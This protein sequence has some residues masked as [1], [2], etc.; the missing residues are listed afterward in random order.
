MIRDLPRRSVVVLLLSLPGISV[1][2][3]AQEP[4]PLKPGAV[5]VVAGK[6]ISEDELKRETSADL[7]KLEMQ[8][9][10]AEA[11]YE[12]GRYQVREN[13][14][15]KLIEDRLLDAEAA[16]L[17]I[18]RA[19]VVA[20]EID[21]KA[22]PP[23]D[24]EVD[25]FYETNK[26]RINRPKDQVGQQIRQYL[27]QQTRERARSA[28]MDRL[29]KEHQAVGS[30]EP[31][32]F[33]VEAAGH[34]ARG[35]SDAPLTIIEFSDFECGF[36]RNFAGVLDSVLKEFGPSVRFVYR[37]FP[38]VEIHPNAQKASEA[39][40]CAADQGKFWE[41]K[42]K[43][44]QDATHLTVPDLKAKAAALGLDTEAFNACL[45][46]GSQT[47]RVTRDLLDGSKVGVT[48]TPA[49]FINGRPFIGAQPAAELTK[50]I[51]EELKLRAAAQKP[52]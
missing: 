21:Q 48:G 14:L 43:L 9:L 28:L 8:K 3:S 27:A 19:E 49:L 15:N 24:A 47:G 31:F 35:P 20:R 38:L 4:P 51:N 42:D 2:L 29:R 17:K 25:A 23:T 52:K 7:F 45:D 13:A 10:Q 26:A 44:F 5:A 41:M 32:R 30:L 1:P 11:S 34:P 36:C 6:P 40:L 50:A 37:Q 39:S 22:K 18:T 16:K 12:R 46:S 33:S